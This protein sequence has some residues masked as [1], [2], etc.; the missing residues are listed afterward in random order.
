VFAVLWIFPYFRDTSEPVLR[1]FSLLSIPALI[2]APIYIWYVDGLVPEHKDGYWA[3]GRVVL[4]QRD[5]IEKDVLVEHLCEWA[6]KLFFL[7]FILQVLT[8]RS[9][10]WVTVDFQEVFNSHPFGYLD[11]FIETMYLVD[12]GFGAVGYLLTLRLFDTHV[13]TTDP[14]VLGWFVCL[15]CY[16]PFFSAIDQNFI[17]YNDDLYWSQWL[18]GYPALQ[19]LWAA[20][21]A[22]S[23]AIYALATVQ[24]GIR[25]GNLS[26]RGIVTNGLYGWLRHPAYLAKN[27]SWWLI[28]IPFVSMNG[29]GEALRLSLMLIVL[30]TIYYLR[31]KTEE[32][33]LSWD[34][35]YREYSEW[36]RQHGLWAQIKY[37][38]S[39]GA[40][41]ATS[42]AKRWLMN[43]RRQRQ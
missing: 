43:S 9:T 30:N 35:A 23:I 8:E 1:L 29:I 25:F 41:A 17:Q 5:Q 3:V 31:A 2:I 26:H 38:L 13:R 14:T 24:L 40:E 34:P 37:G 10:Y 15:I 12:I 42:L 7:Q 39:T 33:H 32:R 4:G 28:S 22:I 18:G 27:A 16:P 6:V 11:I 36:I 20:L 21:I 19:I